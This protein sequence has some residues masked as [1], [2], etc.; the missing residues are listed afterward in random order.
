MWGEVNG[1][2]HA[3]VPGPTHVWLQHYR[4]WRDVATQ[5]KKNHIL[6]ERLEKHNVSTFVCLLRMYL[7]VF[8][9]KLSTECR[10]QQGEG[11]T[12]WP[13]CCRALNSLRRTLD[14]WLLRLLALLRLKMLTFLR[15]VPEQ[16][17]VGSRDFNLVVV[18]LCVLF[19]FVHCIISRNGNPLK[20]PGPASL[21]CNNDISSYY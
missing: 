20:K 5:E 9:V 2:T 11:S 17:N 12:S 19:L 3:P 21:T 18:F 7:V 14:I 4:M 1:A 16:R 6:R 15:L 8:V 13:R 10:E